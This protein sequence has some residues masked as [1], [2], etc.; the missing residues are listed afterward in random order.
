MAE[1]LIGTVSH[2]YDRIGVATVILTE[3]LKRG[4][5]VHFR[6]H[7]TDFQQMVESL[8]IE[9]LDVEQAKAGDHIGLKVSQEAHEKDEVYKVE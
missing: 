7:K 6:G 3:A 5:T 1:K 8:Q 4:D 2:Y 9:H